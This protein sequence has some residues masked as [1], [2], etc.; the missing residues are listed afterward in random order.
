MTEVVKAQLRKIV[1]LAN[2]LKAMERVALFERRADFG[3]K[4][5]SVFNPAITGKTPDFGGSEFLAFEN[6]NPSASGPP[7]ARILPP[8]KA[9]TCAK[10]RMRL[11]WRCDC[12]N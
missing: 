8:P 7:P 1:F 4:D 9:R 6:W 3:R 12:G 11:S 5:Q 10:P 2:G